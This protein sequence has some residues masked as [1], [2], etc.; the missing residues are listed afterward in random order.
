MS[1]K[2]DNMLSSLAKNLWLLLTLV[3]PGLVTYG[4]LR[5]FLIM[6]PSDAPLAVRLAKLDDSTFLCT[7]IVLSIAISQQAIAIAI[8]AF[9]ACIAARSKESAPRFYELFC[10]RFEL[11]VKGKLN[12]NATRIVGNFFL[13]MD[14]TVG[15]MLLLVFFLAY[16][17]KPLLSPVPMILGGLLLAGIVST[18]F[19]LCN[20]EWIVDAAEKGG[21]SP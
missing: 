10:E 4:T 1:E 16:E 5:L 11:A 12:E 9:L 6:D 7:S 19:R 15:V 18:V 3:I 20:A 2:D 13:S 14:V 8:E 17:H 21:P